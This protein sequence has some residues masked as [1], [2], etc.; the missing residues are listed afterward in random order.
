MD[1]RSCVEDVLGLLVG[2]VV[3]KNLELVCLIDDLVLRMILGDVIRL[4]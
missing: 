3:S 1:V 2:K 4:C